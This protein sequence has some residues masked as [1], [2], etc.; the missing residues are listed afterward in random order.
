MSIG[1]EKGKM[2][3]RSNEQ[4]TATLRA[5][6]RNAQCQAQTH[7]DENFLDDHAKVPP[8][9]GGKDLKH[10]EAYQDGCH[11]S[12]LEKMLVNCLR[13]MQIVIGRGLVVE[14]FCCFES[15]IL[16]ESVIG[17]DKLLGSARYD[18][19]H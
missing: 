3:R 8:Y 9:D 18:E 1:R 6:I 12:L 10:P 13:S 11:S 19:K 15:A 14:I 4:G 7:D 5:P 16:S 17:D 2:N